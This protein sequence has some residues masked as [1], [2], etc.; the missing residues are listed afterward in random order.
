M[1]TLV[2][3]AATVAMASPAFAQGDLACAM[4]DNLGNRLVYT[5][6]NNSSNADGSFGGTYVETGF[7]KNNGQE[8]HYPVGNRPIWIFTANRG[9]S[10][11]IWSR[12]APGW[13]I[14]L[15]PITMRNGLYHGTAA[16]IHNNNIV[17][18]GECARDGVDSETTSNVSDRGYA[19][20]YANP[21]S[22]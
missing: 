19:S 3:A 16:L 7:L 17:G 5:F 18:R 21:K 6:A 22:Y 4:Q 15:D 14:G 10:F 12:S 8:V 13:A 11:T 9:G 2:L 1:K 20:S